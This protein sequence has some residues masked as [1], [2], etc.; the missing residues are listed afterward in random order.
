MP[1][2]RFQNEAAGEA[3]TDFNSI[4]VSILRFATNESIES[5]EAS[6]ESAELS[7]VQIASLTA[8][9]APPSNPL[10]VSLSA[11]DHDM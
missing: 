6:P 9:E 8:A 1:S 4:S 7:H 10:F 2:T 11:L 3:I 5:Q